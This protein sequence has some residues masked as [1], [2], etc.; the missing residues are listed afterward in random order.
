MVFQLRPHTWSRG[1][2]KLR[3][4]MS[5]H[6][7]NSVRDRVIGKKWIY[8]ERNTFNRQSVGPSRKARGTR[9]RSCQLLQGWVIS[10]ADEWKEYSMGGIFKN[11]ATTHFF[12]KW[13]FFFKFIYFCLFWVFDASRAFL[14]FSA[15]TS[16]CSGFSCCRAWCFSSCGIRAESLQLQGSI[17]QAQW[18]WRTGLAALWQVGSSWTR[19]EPMS[20]ALAGRFFTTEP[21]RKPTA[22]TF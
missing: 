15:W 21:P 13:A 16:H 1:L 5:H 9:I 4:L 2:L 7:R 11:Q 22:L 17:A 6:R 3:L 8:L 20:P 10:Q 12:L 14:Q 19:D 18:L